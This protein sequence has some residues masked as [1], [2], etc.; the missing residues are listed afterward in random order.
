MHVFNESN[1]LP[2]RALRDAAAVEMA[3]K[4]LQK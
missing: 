4:T 3:L 2:E 1:P